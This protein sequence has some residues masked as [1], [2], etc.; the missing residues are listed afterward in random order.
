MKKLTIL[1]LV[2]ILTLLEC[3]EKTDNKNDTQ[4]SIVNNCKYR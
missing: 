1:S 3:V 4:S 2:A